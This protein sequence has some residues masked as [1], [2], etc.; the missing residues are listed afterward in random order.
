MPYST[1]WWYCVKD[2]PFDINAVKSKRRYEIVKGCKNFSCEIAKNLLLYADEIFDVAVAAFSEYPD[3][4]RPVLNKVTFCRTLK[5]WE[6]NQS[7]NFIMCK[8]NSGRIC[9]YA[10][11]EKNKNC[12]NLQVVKT[13][14]I[15][16]KLQINAA[17]VKFIVDTYLPE[18]YICD[19]E[20][21]LRHH[22]HYQEYLCKYFEFRMVYCKLNI[23]YRAWFKIILFMMFPLRFVFYKISQIRNSKL[24]YNI[25][26]ILEQ[27][28][29]RRT[30]VES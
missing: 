15:C 23:K 29:I 17:I 7:I 18:Y 20:R 3:E 12:A 11:I 26:S 22:T 13:N 6:E 25:V 28:R 9:G 24:L 21:P 27:E 19:G 1:E 2:T 14:P 30:F 5:T 4:Y 10:V 16:E 8:D